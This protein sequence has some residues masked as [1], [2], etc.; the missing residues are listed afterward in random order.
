MAGV[1]SVGDFLGRNF[2]GGNYP[3]GV[4]WEG[5]LQNCK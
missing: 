4:F 1:L 5:I 2:P 3:V